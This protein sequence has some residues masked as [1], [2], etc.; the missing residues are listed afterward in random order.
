MCQ[1]GQ[2]MIQK[3][4]I[5]SENPQNLIVVSSTSFKPLTNGYWYVFGINEEKKLI[6]ILW[7]KKKEE[8][9]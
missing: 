5:F 3:W 9:L 2:N 1:I 6:P 7:Y 4:P 8:D